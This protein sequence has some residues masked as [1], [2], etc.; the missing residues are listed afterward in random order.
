MG[1]IRRRRRVEKDLILFSNIIKI[2]VHHI[3]YYNFRLN[4]G[5]TWYSLD[6]YMSYIKYILYYNMVYTVGILIIYGYDVFMV[7]LNP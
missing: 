3:I 2:W 5:Q 7:S 1:I 6:M 4:L